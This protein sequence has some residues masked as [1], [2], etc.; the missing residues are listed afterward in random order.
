MKGYSERSLL[1]FQKAF[2]TEEA[3]AQHLRAMRWPEG[4]LCPRC[5]HREAWDIPSQ[6]LLDCEGCRG[7]VSLTAGTI[8]H[9]TQTRPRSAHLQGCSRAFIGERLRAIP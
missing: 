4:F 3:C 5:G 2:A 6:N 1:E 9:K 7:R 8:F